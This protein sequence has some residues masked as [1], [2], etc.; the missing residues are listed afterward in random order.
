MLEQ[1]HTWRPGP[2]R[3]ARSDWIFSGGSAEL[4]YGPVRPTERQARVMHAT[5]AGSPV[6]ERIVCHS[7]GV[8]VRAS[9]V[10]GANLR[11]CRA[12]N[13]HIWPCRH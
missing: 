4:V 8:R 7:W 9:D 12:R 3:P 1:L 13:G 5:A 2:T 6:T 10:T 11:V